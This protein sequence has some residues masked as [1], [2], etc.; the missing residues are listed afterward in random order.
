MSYTWYYNTISSL[1][2]EDKIGISP[3]G[4]YLLHDGIPSE[5]VKFRKF[6]KAEFIDKKMMTAKYIVF[7]IK[8]QRNYI[9]HEADRTIYFKFIGE[10]N[11]EMVFDH[12]GFNGSS[13]K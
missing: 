1:Q 11:N 7:R 4:K 5:L 2:Y 10:T 12:V 9:L 8:G 3:D 13:Y 6:E